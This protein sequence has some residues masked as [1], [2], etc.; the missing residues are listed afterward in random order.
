VIDIL[1]RPLSETRL[2]D[3]VSHIGPMRAA[4]YVSELV[5]E[6]HQDN[7]LK[8]TAIPAYDISAMTIKR[9]LG[10][11]ARQAHPFLSC[12]RQ[13]YRTC[14]SDQTEP[15]LR[16]CE[17]CNA[18]LHAVTMYV[19]DIEPELKAA[20]EAFDASVELRPCRQGGDVP[21]EKPA[22]PHMPSRTSRARLSWTA[23]LP[24]Q[25]PSRALSRSYAA[26]L[27]WWCPRAA[28]WYVPALAKREEPRCAGKH[29]HVWR[30]NSALVLPRTS[31]LG[32]ASTRNAP[33]SR[34]TGVN[35]P[36][37]ARGRGR[38]P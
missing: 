26:L 12:C 9:F 27:F 19:A 11:W 31:R 36:R 10:Y 5:A 30:V 1:S 2:L 23:T 38:P 34:C 32:F 16:F 28:G 7:V 14:S 18:Q 6:L 35:R 25:M 8:A 4:W 24:S 33:S 13:I 17:R 20:I 15:L 3:H 22:V 37:P 21:P 29:T